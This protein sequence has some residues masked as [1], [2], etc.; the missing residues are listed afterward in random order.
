MERV[1]PP[2]LSHSQPQLLSDCQPPSGQGWHQEARGG[3]GKQTPQACHPCPRLEG[4]TTRQT[5]NSLLQS[6][7]SQGWEPEIA[8]EKNSASAVSAGD[9]QVCLHSS[10]AMYAGLSGVWVYS[11]A[12]KSFCIHP[13]G[14]TTSD[15]PCPGQG[16]HSDLEHR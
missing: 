3:L 5:R 6:A 4:L 14:P 10:P 8:A 7:F 13:H 16:V 11:Q 12:L 15:Y 9:W 2:P 1:V